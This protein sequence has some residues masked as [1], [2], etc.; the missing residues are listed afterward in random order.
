MGHSPTSVVPVIGVANSSHQI[1]KR[2][3]GTGSR[4]PRLV[5]FNIRVAG[6]PPNSP[7]PHTAAYPGDM[8]EL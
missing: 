4:S 7:P 2:F 3:L 6:K 5:L 8:R 1:M